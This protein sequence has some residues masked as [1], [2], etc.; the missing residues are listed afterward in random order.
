M[1]AL[2][3][4][5]TNP[6]ESGVSGDSTQS[7]GVLGVS[8][9]S[10]KAGLAGVNEADGGN[11]VYGRGKANGLYG[12]HIGSDGAGVVGTS[13]LNDGVRGFTTSSNH[14]GVIGVN[15]NVG[16]GIIGRGR[17]TGVFGLHTGDD[18]AGVVGTSDQNDGVRGF[19][20]SNAH[21]G[22]VGTNTGR[23]VGV[24]G[25]C[26]QGLAGKFEGNVLVTGSLTVHG[27]SIQSLLDRIQQLEQKAP[28]GPMPAAFVGAGVETPAGGLSILRIRGSNFQAA[29]TVRLAITT[30]KTD[31]NPFTE[32]LETTADSV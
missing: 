22:V 16:N 26:A 7:D 28:T 27:V 4:N 10:G 19:S 11:G 8:H 29:E 6:G 25:V 2:I 3:G 12:I 32:T 21:S 5:S 18:G 9:A 31:Q 30:K 20:A 17:G 23:G 14:A 24:L 15:D 13:A 1:A